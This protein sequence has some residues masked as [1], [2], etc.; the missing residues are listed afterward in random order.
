VL[1]FDERDNREGNML[2]FA[3]GSNLWRH[4]MIERCPEH[5]EIG[6]GNLAGW[7]W[8]I[9]TRGYASIVVSEGYYVLGIVYELS[10]SDVRNLDRFEG[11]AKGAYRKETLAVD[12]DG[13]GLNCLVY[14]DPVT[15]E[16]QPREEYITRI[17]NGIRDAGFPDEYITRSLRP[18]VPPRPDNCIS[19]L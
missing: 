10:E 13:R 6:A 16:G 11:V 18:F 9:T 14:I 4:Q 19:E 15:E 17:N 1:L 8:I 2:Y 5:R 12:V 3:Y 7:R